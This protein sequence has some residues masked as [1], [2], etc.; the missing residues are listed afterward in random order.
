MSFKCLIEGILRVNDLNLPQ[1]AGRVCS[2]IGHP[3]SL[4][5]G[6]KVLELFHQ[7]QL[8]PTQLSK[9]S[10]INLLY[11]YTYIYEVRLNF[12]IFSY[13]QRFYWMHQNWFLQILWVIIKETMVHCLYQCK[14]M[15]IFTFKYSWR[16]Y[17]CNKVRILFCVKLSW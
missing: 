8:M 1:Q 11:V 10:I 6:C 14:K 17:K 7:W 15:G 4:S 9:T 2:R 16:S 12:F 3:G 13:M 5:I